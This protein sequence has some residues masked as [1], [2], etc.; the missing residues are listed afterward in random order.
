MALQFVATV[1]VLRKETVRGEN[2]RGPG[3]DVFHLPDQ[4]HTLRLGKVLDYIARE[5][6]IEGTFRE[7]TV[8]APQLHAYIVIVY[9]L[10]A[11]RFYARCEA[12]DADQPWNASAE[13]ANWRIGAAS[14]V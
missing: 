14:D 4:T 8:N 3:R 12:V 2:D 11:T 7:D 9:A 10:G 1:L 5:Y 6:A 13:M